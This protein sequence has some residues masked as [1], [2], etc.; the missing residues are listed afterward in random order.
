VPKRLK[1]QYNDLKRIALSDLGSTAVAKLIGE[2]ATHAR[3]ILGECELMD[4]TSGVAGK[5]Y[6]GFKAQ[7]ESRPVNV[8]L[9]V[10]NDEDFNGLIGALLG[11]LAGSPEEITKATYTTA[12]SVF[13]ANDVSEVGRKAS[14]TF[15]EILIG[16]LV[17][18][19]IKVAP[20]KKVRLPEADGFLP[21]DYVFD[22]G[23][24]SKKTHLPL[25]TS[26]RER[27]VQAWVHQLVLE[28]IF[29][30]DVYRGVLVICGETKRDTRTGGVIEICVPQQWIMFQ[31]R[32][33]K[34]SRIYYLDPPQPY[35]ALAPRIEVKSFGQAMN[36]LP[37]LLH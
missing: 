10:H 13:A 15:F 17:T 22:P 2:M 27:A 31:S 29:G 33:A 25:K 4:L 14:A 34:L 26:T 24:K 5:S 32:V 36:E 30:D 1:Q 12:L 35:L 8:D 28:R 9:Y 21:T 11:D 7:A 19:I 37:S 18:R 16:H 3:E 6:F 20:R 23:R